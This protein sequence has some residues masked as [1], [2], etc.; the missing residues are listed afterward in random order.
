[1]CPLQ[2]SQKSRY[3]INVC[4]TVFDVIIRLFNVVQYNTEILDEF[5]VLDEP[6]SESNTEPQV[7][8][9]SK[10]IP[11]SY[12]TMLN[13]LLHSIPFRISNGTFKC[14][15]VLSSVF[16]IC[17]TYHFYVQFQNLQTNICILDRWNLPRAT[18]VPRKYCF[19]QSLLQSIATFCV[20]MV[21]PKWRQICVDKRLKPLINTIVC[22]SSLD[23]QFCHRIRHVLPHLFC[24]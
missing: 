10:S 21:P 24:N 12:K 19:K 3:F 5:V 17:P 11:V 2:I 22:I 6:Q 23:V 15:I 14:Q 13:D 20:L 8:H 16:L 7:Q 4:K 1:M 18:N 9:K